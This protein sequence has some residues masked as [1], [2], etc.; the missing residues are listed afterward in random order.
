VTLLIFTAVGKVFVV[1]PVF[2]L[3]HPATAGVVGPP[4]RRTAAY[5]AIAGTFPSY[6][7]GHFWRFYRQRRER[8]HDDQSIDHGENQCDYVA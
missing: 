4:L 1:V 6:R 7:M 3:L 2:Q 8:T 5:V